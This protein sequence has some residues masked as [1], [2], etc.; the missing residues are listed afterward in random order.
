M[1]RVSALNHKNVISF[2]IILLIKTKNQLPLTAQG[3]LSKTLSD[4]YFN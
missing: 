2:E 1:M 4:F 3:T